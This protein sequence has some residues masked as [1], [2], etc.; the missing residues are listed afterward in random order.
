[1]STLGTV[2]CGRAE[3]AAE[4][5]GPPAQRRGMQCSAAQ[6]SAAAPA[7]VAAAPLANARAWPAGPVQVRA[8]VGHVPRGRADHQVLHARGTPSAR[9]EA[10][11]M[12][13]AANNRQHATCDV[14]RATCDVRRATCDVQRAT[15]DV[16]RATCS[17]QQTT[18][19]TAVVTKYYMRDARRPPARSPI[20]GSAQAHWPSPN[21]CTWD[22]P[23][24]TAL[25]DGRR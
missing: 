7:D 22:R 21:Q 12:R 1:M 11:N 24:P 4:A 19:G 23:P 8:G 10:Y 2:A 16:Q 13:R 18:C 25:A 5:N 15:C 3:S 14:Q 20:A 9:T 17:V 6:R